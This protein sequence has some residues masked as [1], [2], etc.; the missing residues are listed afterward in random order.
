M[1]D[2]CDKIICNKLCVSDVEFGFADS[3]DIP[4]WLNLNLDV[5]YAGLISDTNGNIITKTLPHN[6]IEDYGII[7]GDCDMFTDKVEKMITYQKVFSKIPKVFVNVILFDQ[8]NHRYISSSVIET[9]SYSAKITSSFTYNKIH[10]LNSINIIESKCINLYYSG[11]GMVINDGNCLTFI[12]NQSYDGSGPYKF[13][14]IINDEANIGFSTSLTVDGY[15]IIAYSRMVDNN[16]VI[17]ICNSLSGLG[18]WTFTTNGNV[19]LYPSLIVTESRRLSIINYD[20]SHL[21]STIID[22]GVF[23]VNQ[24]D[25]YNLNGISSCNIDKYHVLIATKSNIS[26]GCRIYIA[27]SSCEIFNLKHTSNDVWLNIDVGILANGCPVVV[28]SSLDGIKLHYMNDNSNIW[29]THKISDDIADELKYLLLGNG[30]SLIIYRIDN[31]TNLI[32]GNINDGWYQTKLDIN[33]NTISCNNTHNGYIHLLAKSAT[34]DEL[35]SIISANKYKF[36]ENINN[37]R[38]YW[39]A[40]QS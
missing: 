7:S 6:V 19:G 16:L 14:S 22:D 4:L 21:V 36:A 39:Y 31:V 38:L 24:I 25:T 23:L 9:N 35:L 1:V 17:G 33:I 26:S 3:S 37:Y 5:E 2:V 40:I 10:K 27:D 15:P 29:L 30:D 28:S 20:G 13:H 18:K 12:N 8:P 32:Y 11:Y 34:N